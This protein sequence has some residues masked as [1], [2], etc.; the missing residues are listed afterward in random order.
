MASP[1]IHTRKERGDS[2][3]VHSSLDQYLGS[4]TAAAITW[5]KS[6]EVTKRSERECV[7]QEKLFLKAFMRTR[8][9]SVSRSMNVP[10]EDTVE[11]RD[12][13]L[14]EGGGDSD[15]AAPACKRGTRSS[16]PSNCA[17]GPGEEDPDIFNHVESI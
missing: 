8:P 13:M 7:V 16:V 10:R 9:A 14:G 3:V 4:N 11:A 15:P 2:A 17:V 1:R 5:G 6:T 12:I